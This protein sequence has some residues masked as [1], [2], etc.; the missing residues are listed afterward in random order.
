MLFVKVTFGYV[1]SCYLGLFQETPLLSNHDLPVDRCPTH[2]LADSFMCSN[3]PNIT[4]TP[5][6]DVQSGLV[7]LS[8]FSKR[9]ETRPR[10]DIVAILLDA[11]KSDTSCVL[12]HIRVCYTI[13][14]ER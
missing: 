10:P 9:E 1:V 13:D 8:E 14:N 3:W 4:S 7:Y 5:L 12:I 11:L 6:V 2:I